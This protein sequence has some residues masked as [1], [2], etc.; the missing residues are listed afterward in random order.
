MSII[1]PLVFD[2]AETRTRALVVAQ[3]EIYRRVP[4]DGGAAAVAPLLLY[5]R[6]FSFCRCLACLPRWQA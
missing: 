3:A 6:L 2:A 4:L 1:D 5:G